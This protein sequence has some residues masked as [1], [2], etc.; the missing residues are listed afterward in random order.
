MTI[1]EQIQNLFQTEFPHFECTIEEVS[2]RSATLRHPIGPLD[3]RPGGTVS[4]PILMTMADTAAYTALLGEIGII[5]LAVTT[6]LTINFLRKPQPDKDIIAVCHLLKLG[7][8]L[9]V[10]EVSIYSDGDTE[11]VAHA[12]VTY[13]I[14]PRK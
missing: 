14:P 9:A 10:G 6:G 5:P 2:N 4:G 3:L 13:S 1:R 12:V 8:K 11:P 7:K